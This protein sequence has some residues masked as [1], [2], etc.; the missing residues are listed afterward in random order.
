MSF[1]FY[2][3]ETRKKELFSS[4]KEGEV[5]IYSCGPTVYDYAHIGNFRSYIFAD[6]LR[7]A[8]K[9]ASLRVFHALNITDVDDKTIQGTL[10]KKPEAT[11][12]DLREH[13]AFYSRAFWDDLRILNIEPFDF[14]PHATENIEVMVDLIQKLKEKG[15]AYEV[16]GSLYYPIAKFP[17]YGRLSHIDLSQV[18]TGTRYRTDEYTKDDIRDFVLWKAEPRDFRLAWDTP[19][20]HGRPGW[21]IECSAMIRRIFQG[22]IDIHTGGVDL[23]F[24]HHE[25]EIAQSEGAYGKPFVRYWLHCEHLLVNGRKMSKSEG[26]FYTLRD[27]L[28]K[29]YHPAA[30]RYFL[31]A[32]HYRQKLN[33]TL[34]ALDQSKEAVR[35]ILQT[36]LR[37]QKAKTEEKDDKKL[38]L[39][40]YREGFLRELQDDLNMP[41]ALAH[42]FEA[43]RQINALL[44]E[45][46][47]VLTHA[48]KQEILSF[49]Q[50]ID[51]VLGLLVYAH[52]FDY[53]QDIPPELMELL[54]KRTEARK[55]KDFV[56][57]DLLREKI[58][59]QGYRVVDTKEGSF[60]EKV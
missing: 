36:Y 24:P 7:R 23:I 1:Y 39:S 52:D 33:F 18:K 28:Q 30:I 58:S 11:L 38:A 37:S 53:R 48:E 31:M 3:T 44:D 8:L 25:N 15:L 2:N 14:Y 22:P 45:K 42:V 6:V 43:L 41:R 4:L 26:N 16:D 9:L 13:T 46:E 12:E 55:K 59:S 40:N 47:D 32:T 19:L 27:L 60:L 56:L 17:E 49:F 29:G 50:Y 20:G 34:A 10:Q 57:A 35:R 21:H 5:R 54:Q 51:R